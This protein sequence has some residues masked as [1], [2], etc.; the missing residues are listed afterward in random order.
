MHIVIATAEF[1]TE[2]NFSGGLATYTSNLARMLYKNGN[3]VSVVT[4]SSEEGKTAW[5][6]GINVYRVRYEESPKKILDIK[7]NVIRRGIIYIWNLLGRSYVINKC[8]DEIERKNH[9]DIVHFCNSYSLS[10]FRNKKIPAVVRLSNYPSLWREAYKQKFDYS[11][12][13]DRLSMEDKLELVAIKRADAIFGP[14][15]GIISL[16]ERKIN[17]KIAVVESPFVLAEEKN[18]DA[19]YDSVNIPENYFLFYGTLGYLKGIHVITEILDKFFSNYAEMYFV[20]IGNNTMMCDDE[21]RRDAREYICQ[22]VDEHYRNRLIFFDSI[23]NKEQLYP[24]IK[25]ARACVLPSRVDNLPNTCI[26]SM[27]LGQIVIGTNGASFEQ[28]ID[29]GVNGFLIERE[30]EEQLYDKMVKVTKLSQD[31]RENICKRAK[32][33]VERLRPEKIYPQVVEIYE[34]AIKKKDKK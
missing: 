4:I 18:D 10:L 29:D 26:E 9:I 7:I 8:I 11:R 2:K 24:F 20:F 15:R 33:T 3:M 5:E 17:K 19:L 32:E 27:A 16:T 21:D 6:N 31:E 1:I 25:N 14:S 28:L 34:K 13:I 30:N 23:R 22:K 12:A